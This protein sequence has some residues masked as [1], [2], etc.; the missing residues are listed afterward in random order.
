MKIM[1]LLEAARPARDKAWLMEALQASIELEF[2]TIPPYLTAMWSIKDQ[3]SYAARTIREVVYEEMQHMAFACNMLV[4]IGGVPRLNRDPAIPLY[5][6]PLPGGVRPDLFIGLS[7]LT[8]AVVKV[9]MEVEMPEKPL[10]FKQAELAEALGETFATIGA[11]YQ[12]INETFH[13]LEGLTLSVDRQ[14]SGPLA[15]LVITDLTSV[16]KAIHLIRVQGEGTNVSPLEEDAVAT[17]T[18]V[19]AIDATT[20]GVGDSPATVASKPDLAHYYRFQELDKGQKLVYDERT[21]DFRWAGTLAF[22]EVYPVAPIPAGGYLERDVDPAVATLLHAFDSAYTHLLDELQ[23]AWDSEGQ[24]AFWR[25]LEWMFSL[26]DHAVA[27]MQTPIP[28]T[29]DKDSK[30][31]RPIPG[32]EK[33]YGPCFRYLK[34]S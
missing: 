34:T 16:D 22:P 27:L 20:G 24:A 25:A 21:R 29:E 8:P 5:P 9:F 18:H 6:R 2:F 12:A 1:E 30:T 4:A 13:S 11:F 7:G 15:P 10:Q 23:A 17:D 26:R 14:I 32:T 33:A 28:G 3:T 19:Q 31:G